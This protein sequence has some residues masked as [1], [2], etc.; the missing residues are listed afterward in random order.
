VQG[1]SQT[2]CMMVRLILSN[3]LPMFMWL[4][5]EFVQIYKCYSTQLRR[6]PSGRLTSLRVDQLR[7]RERSSFQCSMQR[8]TTS[9]QPSSVRWPMPDIEANR[10]L[11]G[12]SAGPLS[13]GGLR[14]EGRE[15]LEID[16]A[17]YPRT[18][19]MAAL[20]DSEQDRGAYHGERPWARG[21]TAGSSM[22]RVHQFGL[23]GLE[24]LI[25]Q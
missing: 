6:M 15:Q 10:C 11:G 13:A 24:K 7:C 22:S 18:A 17:R 19:A 8:S 23:R 9:E 12:C 2:Q 16:V 1:W 5:P 21:S 4:G 20:I 25:A 3:R 14:R